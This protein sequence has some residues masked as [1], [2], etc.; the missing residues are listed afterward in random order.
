V[1]KAAGDALS[2]LGWRF[3]ACAGFRCSAPPR[4]NHLQENAWRIRFGMTSNV[5]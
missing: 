5:L 1:F 3:G 2:G 4:K